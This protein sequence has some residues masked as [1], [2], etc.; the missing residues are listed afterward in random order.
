MPDPPFMATA[1]IRTFGRLNPYS[2]KQWVKDR[3]Q[4]RARRLQVRAEVFSARAFDRILVN[5]YFSRESV[6][7]AYGLDSR[8]CYLGVD[9]E[10]FEY[11]RLARESFV[12]G[13]GAFVPEKNISLIIRSLGAL[14][15]PPPLIW[16]GNVSPGSH[17]HE[18]QRL[19]ASL[20]VPFEPRL[21]ITDA[22]LIELLNRAA[23][24]VYA[25]RLEPFG[26]APLEANACGLPVVAVAEGGVRE[27]VIDGVNGQLVD[28]E[29]A[30]IGAAVQRL[31]ND[32]AAARRL[33]EAGRQ[34]VLERWTLEAAGD[35]LERHLEESIHLREA[36][37]LGL[38]PMQV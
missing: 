31:F 3:S 23:V 6:L 21:R 36:A 13:V 12:I 26:Y 35:R 29:P 10:L 38:S 32:P 37:P 1:P 30:E 15:N 4:T 11:R 9:S 2:Y 22:E 5:S 33:G 34:L 16:V 27:T 19:A 17:L 8:V 28:A 20:N 14:R 25:P 7:R 24:A 18:L